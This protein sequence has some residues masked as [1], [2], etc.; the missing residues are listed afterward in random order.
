MV[1]FHYISIEWGQTVRLQSYD[2]TCQSLR[3]TSPPCNGAIASGDCKATHQ[4][5]HV[6]LWYGT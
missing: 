4:I 6:Y 5:Q 3:W 2:F 1:H